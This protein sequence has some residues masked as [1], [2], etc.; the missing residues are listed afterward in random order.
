MRFGL[1]IV[2]CILCKQVALAAD[3]PEKPS[4]WF[5]YQARAH[6]ALFASDKAAEDAA[7][8]QGA[9]AAIIAKAHRCR[10]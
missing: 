1:A 7:R 9:T 5:C 8:A 4:A 6:R 3:Q 10:R 2:L